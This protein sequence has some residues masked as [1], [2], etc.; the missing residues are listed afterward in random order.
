M[1]MKK[2]F[3]TALAVFCIAGIA[4]AGTSYTWKANGTGGWDAGA[5]RWTIGTAQ[6]DRVVIE[7]CTA[8]M[9]DADVAWVNANI[10]D[11]VFKNNGILVL[12]IA[13]DGASLTKPDIYDQSGDT[14]LLVKRGRGAFTLARAKDGKRILLPTRG[15]RIEEG[16]LAFAYNAGP[17]EVVAP[18]RLR[19][20]T[21]NNFYCYGLSGDG[22]VTNDVVKQFCFSGGSLA[23]PFVFSGKFLCK[24][25]LTVS[26]GCQYITNPDAAIGANGD[27]RMY[28]GSVG[29]QKFGMTGSASSLGGKSE[30]WIRENTQRVIYL[31]SG[32]E[33]TDHQFKFGNEN[34]LVVTMDAGATGGV[35]FTGDFWAADTSGRMAQLVLDKLEFTGFS[36]GREVFFLNCFLISI[37]TGVFFVFRGAF[38][39]A[40]VRAHVKLVITDN[41]QR[42]VY[43]G[44]HLE[45]ISLV[46]DK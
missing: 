36:P 14:A 2:V 34:A 23:K 37:E 40:A 18:A 39:I 46:G 28:N 25:D 8:T 22:Y 11:I 10:V 45:S 9:T 6:S 27:V 7:N 1:R 38:G 21:D 32:N 15:V 17:I 12:D 30:Y 33:T 4:S 26:G 5:S 42:V 16:E 43:R 3:G 35:T 20:R 41:H 44:V 24:I 13:N 31:G 19:P 29:V